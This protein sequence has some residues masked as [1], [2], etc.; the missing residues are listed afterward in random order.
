MQV[1]NV[2]NAIPAVPVVQVRHPVHPVELIFTYILIG[3]AYKLV[4]T[5]TIT[6]Q[7]LLLEHKEP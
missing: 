6:F 7:V 5:I 2:N 4:L 3:V 1:T